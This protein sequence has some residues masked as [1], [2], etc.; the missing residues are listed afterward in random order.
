MGAGT[1]CARTIFTTASA[2]ERRLAG[3]AISIG[4]WRSCEAAR[5]RTL[6]RSPSSEICRER[7]AMPPSARTSTTGMPASERVAGNSPSRSNRRPTRRGIF[8]TSAAVIEP[9]GNGDRTIMLSTSRA[10]T[11]QPRHRLADSIGEA[12][13]RERALGIPTGGTSAAISARTTSRSCA[14][15]RDAVIRMDRRWPRPPHREP[16]S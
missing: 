3:V 11:V 1:R 4:S 10:L 6:V 9:M 12:G 8:S 5:S 14:R 2:E 15:W 7:R 13:G 16:R